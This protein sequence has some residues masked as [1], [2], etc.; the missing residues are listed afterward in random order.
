VTPFPEIGWQGVQS[1]PTG[2]VPGHCCT[3]LGNAVERP[4]PLDGLIS[5]G[6]GWKAG[7]LDEGGWYLTRTP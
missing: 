1:N 4:S 3:N 7:H 5:F 6:G 2:G